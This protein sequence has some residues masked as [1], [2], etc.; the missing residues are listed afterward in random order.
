MTGAQSRL[1]T[2]ICASCESGVSDEHMSPDHVGLCEECAADLQS[3]IDADAAE[4]LLDDDQIVAV[5]LETEPSE[6]IEAAER[7]RQF[8]ALGVEAAE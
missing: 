8:L 4:A 5:L 7:A 2:S 6:V 1:S 3:T